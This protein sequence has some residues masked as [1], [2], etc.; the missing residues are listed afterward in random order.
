ML[1]GYDWKHC[2]V[3][4]A[5]CT[6]T[7]IPFMYSKKRNCAALVPISTVMCLWAIYTVYF[8][9][10]PPIFLQQNRQ[11]DPRNIKICHRNMN[12]EIETVAAQFLSWEYLFRIFGIVSLQW[13]GGAG[14]R[15]ERVSWWKCYTVYVW[16]WT[17]FLWVHSWA[18]RTLIWDKQRRHVLFP[19]FIIFSFFDLSWKAVKYPNLYHLRESGLQ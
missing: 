6:A 11:T 16:N 15:G 10:R 13:I 1:F 4:F 9:V 18:S 14:A 2:K 8:H 12:V 7:K 19:S 3:C 5:I 17:S